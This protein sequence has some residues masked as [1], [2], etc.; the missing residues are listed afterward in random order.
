MR[1]ETE[2]NNNES[3]TENRIA[4][5]LDQIGQSILRASRDEL[6]FSMHF[7]DVALSSLICFF[8]WNRWSVS[9]FSSAAACRNVPTEQDPCKQRLF[10]YGI[11]LY[12]PAYDKAGDGEKNLESE[13]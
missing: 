8:F 9:L 2:V 10:S 12:F 3:E 4:E 1:L 7:L 13:L 11:A 5:K 6:Y